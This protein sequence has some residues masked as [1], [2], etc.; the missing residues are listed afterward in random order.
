MDGRAMNENFAAIIEAEKLVPLL[1]A[2][3]TEE[4]VLE[5]M[6]GASYNAFVELDERP[7]QFQPTYTR[8][9]WHRHL[10]RARNN[11]DNDLFDRLVR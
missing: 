9:N 5:V 10:R 3:T 2:A 4:R 1:E 11:P 8:S 6:T 7:G